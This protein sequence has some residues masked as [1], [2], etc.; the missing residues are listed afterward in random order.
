MIS[1]AARSQCVM[2][3]APLSIAIT[4]LAAFKVYHATAE[5]LGVTDP[6][7][8]LDLRARLDAQ[9]HYDDF[10]VERVVKVALNTA[11]PQYAL[12]AT[13]QPV[14]ERLLKQFKNAKQDFL[15]T[16]ENSS[17]RQVAKDAMDALRLFRK[18]LGTYNRFYAVLSQL[19]DY[20]N[21]ALERRFIFFKRLRSASKKSS[22]G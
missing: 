12:S 17:E 16:A 2:C 9:G 20:G 10:E 4:I 5:L 19:F 21:T 22:S 3:S 8:I 7:A 18:D 15:A 13:I 1:T 14:A 6:A 11:S